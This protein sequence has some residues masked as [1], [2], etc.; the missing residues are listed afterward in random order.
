VSFKT[1]DLCDEFEESVWMAEPLFR[2]YGGAGSFHGSIV[3]VRVFEDNVL[4]RETLEAEGQR[5]VLVVDGGG[6]TRCALMGDR[7]ARFAYENGWAGVVI[8]GCIRDSEEISK[9]TVGVKALHTVP[10]RSAKEG[11]GERDVPVSFAGITFA[12]GHYLYAD[13][14]GIIV[15]NR[16]LLS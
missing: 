16:D 3:T 7:L 10:K 14:D 11:V 6:S 12:P 8:N 4:V 15:A 13:A 2:D 5:R 9:I 1:P